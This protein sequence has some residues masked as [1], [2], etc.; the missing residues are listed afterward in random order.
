MCYV[1]YLFYKLMGKEDVEL[2]TMGYL[3]LS[4]KWNLAICNN[5][6]GPRGY[7]VE[8]NK[9]NT[10]RQILQILYDLTYIK[11]KINEQTE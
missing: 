6:S 7:Y 4:N 2:H 1:I 10:E 5:M 3:L 9:S 11:T 8:W